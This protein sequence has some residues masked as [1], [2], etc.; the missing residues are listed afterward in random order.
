MTRRPYHAWM[1][2]IEPLC[3]LVLIAACAATAG[4]AS[5]GTTPADSALVLQGNSE[6][7]AFRSLT[8][9]AENRIHFEFA[10]PELTIE[11]DALAVL[12]G[13]EASEVLPKGT[14]VK[15]VVGKDPP[16]N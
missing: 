4:A 12:N 10:R 2:T 6:E 3:V 13:V 11:L 8:V 15:R 7:T 16:K 1:N 9:E 14:L 5:V